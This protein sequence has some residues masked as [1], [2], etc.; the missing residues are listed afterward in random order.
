MS[1]SPYYCPQ[2]HAGTIRAA[3]SAIVSD[4]VMLTAVDQQHLQRRFPLQRSCWQHGG[5][6]RCCRALQQEEPA[7]R[8][9]ACCAPEGWQGGF[10]LRL[11]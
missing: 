6:E 8:G 4:R 3:G 1:M 9:G 10:Y 11:G 2:P 5:P 7:D